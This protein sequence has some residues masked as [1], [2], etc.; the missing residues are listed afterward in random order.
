[1]QE[2]KECAILGMA[3]MVASI[4][5]ALPADELVKVLRVLLERLRNEITRLPAVRA[6]ATI[7]HSAAAVDMGGVM[8]AVLVELTS[9]LRKANRALRQA[10]LQTLEV[11]KA[12][13]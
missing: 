6:F 13:Q 8:D 5:G 1:M 11:R 4:P 12:S 9:F 3:T 10:S 2:V 7:C